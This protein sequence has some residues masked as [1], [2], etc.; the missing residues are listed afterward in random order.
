MLSLTKMQHGEIVNPIGKEWPISTDP[1]FCP[2]IIDGKCNNGKSSGIC[3][4]NYYRYVG[5]NENYG[6]MKE[7]FSQATVNIISSQCT[8]NLMG[9]LPGNRPIIVADKV[10]CHVMS[11]VY[12]DR[13][14]KVGDIYTIFNIPNERTVD[15]VQ[16]MIDRCIEIITNN[17]STEY[18]MIECNSKLTKWTTV[19][20]S[21]NR[22]GLRSHPI[23][24]IREKNTNN[25]GTV[26]FMNY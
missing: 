8:Q 5:W 15:F 21:F 19:L 4:E 9:V 17:I 25:R 6:C 2:D 11:N 23:I 18:G 12:E 13:M 7:Y 16:E 24:K 20:G 3:D 26:S 14:S 10:I 1:I 22:E